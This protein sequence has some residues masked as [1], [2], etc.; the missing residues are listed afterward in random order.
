MIIFLVLYFIPICGIF[1]A[2]GGMIDYNRNITEERWYRYEERR[3]NYLGR[4]HEVSALEQIDLLYEISDMIESAN[5]DIQEIY[6]LCQKK[7]KELET[8]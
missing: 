8:I 6:E 3:L 4:I 5:Y 2:V 7:I 1:I